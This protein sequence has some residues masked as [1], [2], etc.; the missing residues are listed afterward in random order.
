MQR[1]LERATNFFDIP[2]DIRSRILV[3]AAGLLLL[4]TFFTPIWKISF[5]S[6]RYPDGLSL[7][8][9]AHTMEGGRKNDL[10]EINALNYY[11]GM[12]SLDEE[13]FLQFRWFPFMIGAVILLALRAVVIG[14]MSK[15]VDLFFLVTY[16]GLFA[17]WSFA[18][19]LY[20]YGHTLNPGAAVQIEPF[21]PPMFGSVTVANVTVGASPQFGA[22]L[23][24]LVPLVLLSAILLSRTTYRNE[25]LPARDYIR[26][27]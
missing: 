15:L 3:L 21:T 8:V 6:P 17:V 24:V 22:Y 9:Y 19:T 1:F 20:A 16:A 27:T 2:L 18:N 25:H 23:I 5:H 11:L 12:R 14:K 10:L 13:R 7:K 4:P 26:T